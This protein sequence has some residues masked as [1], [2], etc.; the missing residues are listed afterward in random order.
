MKF[1]KR[2]Q[3]AS[4]SSPQREP[5]LISKRFAEKPSWERERQISWRYTSF[6]IFTCISCLRKWV[7]WKSRSRFNEKSPGELSTSWHL[8]PNRTRPRK[9]FPHHLS[10]LEKVDS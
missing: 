3:T 6:E 4:E 9:I 1:C 7:S 2:V 5:C 8:R 10:I